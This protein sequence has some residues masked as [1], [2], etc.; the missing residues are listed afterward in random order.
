MENKEKDR[1]LI[2]GGGIGGL[3]AAIALRRKGFNVEVYEGREKNVN[4]KGTGLNIWTNA[5]LALDSIGLK[6][7]VMKMGS[8][9]ERSEIRSSKGKLLLENETRVLARELGAPSVAI[10]RRDLVQALLSALD[11]I[12][13]HYASRCVAYRE[14][15]DGVT[16]QLDDGR[17]VKGAILIGADGIRSGIRAQL[18]GV[19]APTFLGQT[20]WRGISNIDGDLA[21]DTFLMIWG[22]R[23]V[24]GG[25]YHVDST[26]ACWFVGTNAQPGG[27]DVA[28]KVRSTL[29]QL[30]DG[31]VG[32]L[33]S[34]VGATPEN[35]IIRTDLYHHASI[36]WGKGRVT[37]LGDAA[38]AMPTVLGQGACQSIEDAVV[39]ADSLAR[40]VNG[41]EGLRDYEQ[42][43]I[44]RV[45]WVRN[46]VYKLAKFQGWDNPFKCW[47]RN[48]IVQFV[49]SKG[50]MRMWRELLSFS[51][52]N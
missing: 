41:I 51:I 42:R 25:C 44:P 20:V 12:P 3:T 40:V 9:I 34:I 5:M 18:E 31:M 13:V 11:D 32:P 7:A 46:K 43:R 52:K 23:G 4:E 21:R 36:S 26:H 10:R 19:N 50:S 15:A 29:K 27:Q 1:V 2:V 30:V 16:L 33:A 24:V 6:S 45:T 47:L 22:D 14:D 8:P 48:N 39:L 35:D 38:H 49:P 37:L 28:G 17:E